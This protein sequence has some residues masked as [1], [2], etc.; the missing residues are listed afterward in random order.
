MNRQVCVGNITDGGVL[1]SVIVNCTINGAGEVSFTGE[2]EPFGSRTQGG[3]AYGQIVGSFKGFSPH[4]YLSIEDI[5][6]N[7]GWS[8]DMVRELFE[9]WNRWHLNHMRAGCSH[10][11]ANWGVG[12]E[13]EVVK[14][15][16]TRDAL[17]EIRSIKD[18]A[19][20]QLQIT[21]AVQISEAS[22]QLLNLPYQTYETPDAN[23]IA[24]GRYEV[25]SR[26]MRRAG[27]VRPSEH[28]CGLL[29][30]PCEVCGYK[31]GTQ[32]LKEELPGEVRAR[33][34]ALMALA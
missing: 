25:E 22:R 2:L 11:R 16:L 23:S 7:Y 31:Y 5:N 12:A 26:E 33:I 21:G 17:G 4:G 8:H 1:Y 3:G 6:L 27:H 10:Q 19:L 9:L 15:K 24:S 18:D 13:L 29:A 32:W 20:D 14:Y 30:E 34:E 28:P